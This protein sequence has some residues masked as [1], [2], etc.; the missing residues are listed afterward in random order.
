MTAIDPV[1][2][3]S[4]E[5]DDPAAIRAYRGVTRCFCDPGCRRGFETAVEACL[6]KD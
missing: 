6:S 4:A 5:Q 3:M 1:C 2:G